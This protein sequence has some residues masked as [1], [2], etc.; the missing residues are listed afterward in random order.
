MSTISSSFPVA[1]FQAGVTACLRS[2]SALRTA[3][4]R[5]WGGNDSV[6]KADDLRDNIYR[7]MTGSTSTPTLELEDLEDNLAIFM[8]EEFSVVLEDESEKQVA[9]TLFELYAQ[10]MR[11]QTQLAEQLVQ[12]ALRYDEQIATAY[13]VCV[14]S[15]EHDDDDDDDDDDEDNGD[16]ENDDEAMMDTTGD[17]KMATITAPLVV[18]EQQQPVQQPETTPTWTSAADYASQSLFGKPKKSVAPRKPREEPVEAMVDDDGFATV[19]KGRRK[20]KN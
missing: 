4:E 16:N 3:V 18:T 5:G 7:F 9:L 13:P 8:E 14:K 15:T 19:T 17:D 10:C 1:E 2:W 12:A 11:G 20:P 6:T